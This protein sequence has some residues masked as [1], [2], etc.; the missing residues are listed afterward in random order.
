M[1][2]QSPLL[3]GL[4]AETSLHAGA[5][6]SLGVIDLPIQR[7]A[8]TGYPVVYGSGVK[9]ALRA[10]AAAALGKTDDKDHP[11]VTALFGPAKVANDDSAHAG[12]LLVGDARLAALPIRSLT[13]Q[14]KWVTCPYLL[15]RLFRDAERLGVKL[16]DRPDLKQP[17]SYTLFAATEAKA[18]YLEEYRFGQVKNADAIGKAAAVLAKLSDIDGFEKALKSQ[19]VI[20]NDNDFTHLVRAAVPVTP[21]VRL[22]SATKTAS[23]GALWYEETLPPETLL[24]VPIVVM[25][26]RGGSGETKA[27]ENAKALR[28]LFEGERKPYLQLGGNET[29]GMG[30][31]RTRFLPESTPKVAS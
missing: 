10:H 26:G 25:D 5:G 23:G 30:W 11:T 24:Y 4:H 20:V 16:G 17:E 31:C 22:D 6:A 21:H 2:S 1:P 7:E 18:V 8:H 3:L 27:K 15:D 9:G 19:L 14:F 12:A 28:R 29:V 13:T